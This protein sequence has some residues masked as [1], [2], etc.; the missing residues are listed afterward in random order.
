MGESDEDTRPPSHLGRA[1]LEVRAMATAVGYPIRVEGR[2]DP[3]LS[4]W[5]WLVK[6][7]LV[8]PHYVVLAFLWL[9]FLVMSVFAFVAILVT[10]RYPRTVFDFNVGVLRWTWRVTYYAYGALGTDRYPPFTLNDVP[11]YPARLDVAYPARLSRGLVLVKW[12]LLAIPHYIVVGFFL[13]GASYLGWQSEQADARWTGGGLIGILVLIAAVVL[14]VTGRYPRSVFDLV[15]GLNR[16]VLRVAAYAGLMTDRYPPFRLDMG[17]SE[18]AVLAVGVGGVGAGPGAG[19]TAAPPSPYAGSGPQASAPYRTSDPYG[20]PAPPPY[21]PEGTTRFSAGRVVAV[22]VSAVVALAA[23][24][25]LV[26]GLVMLAVD[27]T[28][29][30]ADGLLRTDPQRFE[31]S[32]SALVSEDLRLRFDG[33]DWLFAREV[34]GDVQL[35]VTSEEAEPVFVGVA[36]RP[37]AAA[38]L[39]GVARDVVARIGDSEVTYRARPGG[40]PATPPATETFW[41][42]SATGTG[43]QNV[44]WQPQEGDW[45]VVVMNADGSPGIA[46]DADV[47][48][49]LPILTWVAVGLV[50]VGLVLL[51]GAAVPLYL[52]VRR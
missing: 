40:L 17:G 26:G 48:A 41:V 22:V 20:T 45:V 34:T 14:T 42:E 51:L 35:Q 2:M 19:G 28:Q 39:D 36:P 27:R 15:L 21:R 30:D 52:A 24:G 13:G 44:T 7:L 46:V 33:P 10:G 11:D 50:A 23:L 1:A 31:T 8:L 16:W 9:A 43:V 47:A 3:Q 37:A 5:L 4:R 49:E 29:R 18:P 6:W 38:Y 32:T 25:M 12:W